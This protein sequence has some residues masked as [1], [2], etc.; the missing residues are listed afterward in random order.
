[1]IRGYLYK[2]HVLPPI[3]SEPNSPV[4]RP[5]KVSRFREATPSPEDLKKAVERAQKTKEIPVITPDSRIIFRSQ[6][7]DSLIQLLRENGSKLINHN[8][9][10]RDTIAE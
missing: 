7:D 8:K 4:L 9:E 10:L 5:E 6:E 1:M 2:E 3:P